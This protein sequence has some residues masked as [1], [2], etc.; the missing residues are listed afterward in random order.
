M[1]GI[2]KFIANTVLYLITALLIV[3]AISVSAVRYYPNFS[4][5]AEREIEN[6]LG[7]I[8]NADITIESLDIYRR[9]V[10]PRVIAQNV[11]ITDRSN[12]QQSWKIKKALLGVDVTGS[13]LSRSLRVKEVGLEGMDIS[14][15]RD[16]A[17]DLHINQVFLLPREAMRSSGSSN[18]GDVHLRL[19]DSNLHWQD[20]ISDVDYQFERINIAINPISRGYAV[21]LEGDLPAV[22]GKSVKAYMRITGDL[23]QLQQTNIKFY[24]QTDQLRLA[25]IAKQFVGAHGDK[26][27]IVLQAETWGELQ[28]LTLQ[29]LRGSLDV[30]NVAAGTS[31]AGEKLCLSDDYI[32]QI[33]MHFSWQQQENSWR[34]DASKFRVTTAQHDWQDTEL[35]FKT[36]EHSLNAKSIFAH[37]GRMNIGAICNTLRSYS[38]H[39]VRFE[40]HLEQYRFNAQ[41]ND[42]LI[43]FDLGE[44]HE[45]SFQYSAQVKDAALWLAQGDRMIRGVSGHI[46]GG[47][48]GGKVTL[49][50]DAIGIT[51]PQLY[52]GQNLSV[53]AQGD[54]QW[55][56]Q[57]DHYKIQSERLSLFNNELEMNARLRAE[58]LGEDIYIDSQVHIP[59]ADANAVGS[60]FPE[61]KRTSKTKKWLSCMNATNAY[62]FI[63][64]DA[65]TSK[66]FNMQ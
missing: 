45:N 6:R 35:H 28:G 25:E 65:N 20:E 10:P 43:R 29:S 22:L 64:F 1:V 47:D 23:K 11:T 56:H 59:N 32:R 44:E 17:G 31:K 30:Q 42:L 60:Y 34:F 54:V 48:S 46:I 3:I 52:P 61:L 14:I 16:R 18:Y 49:D 55:H 19:L 62:D 53:A 15:R 38:P 4:D 13:L 12:P 51:L 58:L 40:N 39:I 41:I 26:V 21:H 2:A 24:I 5:L 27:P 37:I 50:A 9:Q 66:W 33:S 57:G 63:H 36:I 8:L 7:D